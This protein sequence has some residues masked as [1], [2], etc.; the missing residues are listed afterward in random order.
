[1]RSFLF[2][3]YYRDDYAKLLDVPVS[4]LDE[5][6]ELCDLYNVDKECI[7]IEEQELELI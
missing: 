4:I 2:P 3:E 6:Q 1:M 7:N 5:V